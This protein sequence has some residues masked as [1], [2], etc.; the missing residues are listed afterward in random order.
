MRAPF[1]LFPAIFI[2]CV[3]SIGTFAQSDLRPGYIIT[4]SNDTIFG[5]VVYKEVF[6]RFERC[7]FLHQNEKEPKP[8]SPVELRGYGITGSR[9]YLSRP[10]ALDTGSLKNTFLEIAVIGKANLL[11]AYDRFF[12]D[13]GEEKIY[14]LIETKETIY[15]NEVAYVHTIKKY[16]GVLRSALAEC[17]GAIALIDKTNYNIKSISKVVNRYNA[18]FSDEGGKSIRKHRSFKAHIGVSA[19]YS[20]VNLGKFSRSEFNNKVDPGQF[21]DRIFYPG[22]SV[23]IS[24][25]LSNENLALHLDLFYQKNSFGSF[26]KLGNTYQTSSWDYQSINIPIS[27]TYYF[28]GSRKGIRF[29]VDAGISPYWTLNHETSHREDTETGNTITLNTQQQS[30]F[31]IKDQLSIFLAGGTGISYQLFPAA[32]LSSKVRYESGS[33]NINESHSIKRRGLS[34]AVSILFKLSK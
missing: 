6:S 31:S 7:V 14:E 11:S 9:H 18:C 28:L 33:F 1:K 34:V 27:I 2:I 23:E 10:L 15:K 19:G 26:Y 29:F 25:P 32:S 13:L 3:S 4:Q 17:S 22:I 30:T 21:N 20:S 16:K 12:L 5:Q 24:S 8:Y